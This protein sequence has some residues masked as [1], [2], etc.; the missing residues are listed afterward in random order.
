[1]DHAKAG[2]TPC[3]VEPRAPIEH[4]RVA[5]CLGGTRKSRQITHDTSLHLHHEN[6]GVRG[7]DQTCKTISHGSSPIDAYV[8][9]IC[10]TRIPTWF[11]CDFGDFVFRGFVIR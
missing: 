10:P 9:R 6:R 8:S 5:H 2:A 4:T 3:S 7:C 1:M 11:Y